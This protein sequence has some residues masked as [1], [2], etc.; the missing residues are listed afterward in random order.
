M[1]VCVCISIYIYITKEMV[2]NGDSAILQ[3]M[4]T[5]NHQRHGTQCDIEYPTKRDPA[6]SPQENAITV[7]GTRLSKSLP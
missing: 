5:R 7:F 6:Q 1:C 3:K 4:K 2:A